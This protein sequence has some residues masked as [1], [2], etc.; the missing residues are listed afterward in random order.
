MIS[1]NGLCPWVGCRHHC[2]AHVRDTGELQ[3]WEAE[4]AIGKPESVQDR[5]R[6][7]SRGVI[8][9]QD[10]EQDAQA[11][12][13]EAIDE[14]VARYGS[15][16]A[17]DWAEATTTGYQLTCYGAASMVVS[18]RSTNTLGDVDHPVCR[19]SSRR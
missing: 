12:V 14:L 9:A 6:K 3:P 13:L 18:R 5:W 8:T 15:P 16:C 17:L 1:R 7:G 4:R 11:R 2:A 19:G 10:L